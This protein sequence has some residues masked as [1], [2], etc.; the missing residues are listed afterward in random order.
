MVRPH[1]CID[2]RAGRRTKVA[3]LTAGLVLLITSSGCTGSKAIIADQAARLDSL[4]FLNDSLETELGVYRDSIAFYDF[5]DSGE[6]DRDMRFMDGRINRLT[7]ELAVCLDGGEAFATELVDDLF[8]P[9]SANLTESGRERLA[10]LTERLT[11]KTTTGYIRIEGYSDST[12]PTGTLKEKYP[13]NWELS[14][15]R[16]GAVARYYLDVHGIDEARLS[17]VSFGATQPIAS[18]ATSRGRRLNRR[19]RFT[20]IRLN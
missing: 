19:I 3:T 1:D 16:A 13:S 10:L 6:F 8:E 5:I 11:E 14:A 12:R 2:G 17:V 9:A 15:A 20:H 4:E 18:N 7:Y